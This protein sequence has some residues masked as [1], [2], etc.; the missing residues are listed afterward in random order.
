MENT[1]AFIERANEI[2]RSKELNRETY[3]EAVK[4]AVEAAN[5]ATS[6]RKRATELAAIAKDLASLA[7]TYANEHVHALAIPLH[8]ITDKTQA[9]SVVFDDGAA[10]SLT[11]GLG[12]PKRIDGSNITE[13]F[14]KSLPKGWVKTKL[15]LSV[16]A[17][18]TA[19]ATERE[20]HG[21]VCQPQPTWKRLNS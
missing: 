12:E 6:F 4:R 1:S 20:E 14:K 7:F 19:S 2:V 9:G 5:R 11:G 8:V 15:D 13:A 21:L 16:D 3:E 18:K 10:Y 17:I